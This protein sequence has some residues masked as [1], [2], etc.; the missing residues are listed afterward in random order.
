MKIVVMS[1]SHGD[2]MTV[3]KI[4]SAHK[5]ASIFI[6]LGDG[7]NDIETVRDENPRLTIYNVAGN[8]DIDRY[9]SSTPT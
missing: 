6:H 4:I 3:R 7:E 9:S 2:I 1:D 8:C 5:D